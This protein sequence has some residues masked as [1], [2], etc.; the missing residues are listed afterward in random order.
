MPENDL[1]GYSHLF[2]PG[3]NIAAKKRWKVSAM[4]LAYRLNSLGYIS[5]WNYRSLLIELGKRGYRSGEPDGIEREVSTVLAKV[6][7][8]LWSKGMTKDDIAKDLGIPLE[9]IEALIFRLSP[10]QGTIREPR[11]PELRLVK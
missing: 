4:A 1:M 2:T 3:Q 5:E 9:E 10:D 11:K 6:L 8:A 7:A